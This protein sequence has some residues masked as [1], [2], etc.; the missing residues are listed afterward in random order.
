ML[1]IPAIDLIAGKVVR[2]RKGSYDDVTT[3]PDAPE[4]IARGWR[5][6]VERL[7]VVDLEGARSGH[8]EQGDVIRRIVQAFGSGVQLGG[9]LRSLEAVEQAFALGVDR[10]VLGT[11]AVKDPGLVQR[12]AASFPHR[13]IVAVDARAGRVATDGWEKTS[14]IAAIDLVEEL[15]AWPLSGV[16]YTDIERDGMEVGPNVAETARLARSTPLPVIASGGVGRLEH[17]TALRQADGPIAAAIVGRALH[18]GRFSLAQAV[19]H[20]SEE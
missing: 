17:L 12:A 13:V 3:Y 16:L 18:E 1:L 14:E 9:G 15:S 8:S 10:V 6:H 2:L 5:A 4:D 20:C 7:H 19:E 11:A